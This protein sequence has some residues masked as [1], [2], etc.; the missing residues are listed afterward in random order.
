MKDSAR[1]V[2]SH[3]FGLAVIAVMLSFASRHALADPPNPTQRGAGAEPAPG[4]PESARKDLYGDPLPEGALL[5]MGSVRLRHHTAAI[6]FSSDGKTLISAGG[7]GD[8]RF[9]D[10]A[11][12]RELNR[13]ELQGPRDLQASLR[14]GQITPDGKRFA[15][16]EQGHTSSSAAVYETGTGKLLQRFPTEG[17]AGCS[18]LISRAGNMLVSN[19]LSADLKTRT[20]RIWD[21][22]TGKRR[23]EQVNVSIGMGLALSPDGR[24]L[25]CNDGKDKPVV[26]D[27]I[28]RVEL[29]RFP[30]DASHGCF[31]PDGKVLACHSWNTASGIHLWDATTLKEIRVLNQIEA[32]VLLLAFPTNDIVAVECQQK[33]ELILLDAMGKKAPVRIPGLNRIGSF[34]ISPDQKTLACADDLTIRIFDTVTGKPLHDF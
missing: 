7:I 2:K 31:S 1:Y 21:V 11:T 14:G 26:W 15:V 17:A 22:M 24:R 9:W 6:A 10:V 8:I 19:A 16:W 27:T 4:N 34:A 23:L 28:S 25:V 5:R 29:G 20:T 30:S 33:N 3:R 32:N 12:G 13:V 18:V